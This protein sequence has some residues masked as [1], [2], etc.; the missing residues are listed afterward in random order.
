MIGETGTARLV[1][2]DGREEYGVEAVCRRFRRHR[3][4][5]VFVV[6]SINGLNGLAEPAVDGTGTRQ[7]SSYN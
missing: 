2:Q 1:C 6:G 4:I 3:D 7:P 5:R